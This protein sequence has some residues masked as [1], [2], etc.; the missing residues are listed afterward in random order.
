[1]QTRHE[2][3]RKEREAQL[4]AEKEIAEA[5]REA[6]DRARAAAAGSRA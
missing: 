4:L 3:L 1:M 5:E 6:E 2:Q